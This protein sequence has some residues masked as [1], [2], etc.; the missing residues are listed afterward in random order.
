MSSSISPRSSSDAQR[1]AGSAGSP[2]RGIGGGEHRRHC[3]DR[4]LRVFT[5]VSAAKI[6]LEADSEA[7]HRA[8]VIFDRLGGKSAVRCRSAARTQGSVPAGRMVTAGRSWN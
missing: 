5:A 1:G 8:R 7:Y 3:P 4:N 6:R 2:D